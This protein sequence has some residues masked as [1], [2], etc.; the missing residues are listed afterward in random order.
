MAVSTHHKFAFI[1]PAK[2]I[3]IPETAKI[4]F[5]LNISSAAY[6]YPT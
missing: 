4:N 6:E 2:P 5:L 1:F 3:K